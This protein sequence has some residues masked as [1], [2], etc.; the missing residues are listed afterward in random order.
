MFFREVTTILSTGLLFAAIPVVGQAADVATP[1]L[2][3]EQFDSLRN[4]I[5]PKPGGFD[6]VPWMTDLWRARQEAAAAGKPIL[7]WVGDGH[8]LGWT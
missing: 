4:L 5:K 6:D 2:S 1:K 3:P 8:P 7:I